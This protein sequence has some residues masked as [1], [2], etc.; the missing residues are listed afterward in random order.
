MA[1][2]TLEER[3]AKQR[4]RQQRLRDRHRAER[5]P[6]RDDV[7]R[8]MLFWTISSYLDQGRQDWI[9]ELADAVVGVLVDQGFDERAADEVF[10]DL[11]DRYASDDQ[12]FRRK[13]HLRG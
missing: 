12:P 1:R 10:D 5:R 9:E 4:E 2:Q 11:V 3:N 7:A 6:D 8:A 13:V